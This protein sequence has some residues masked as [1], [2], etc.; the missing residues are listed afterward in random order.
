MTLVRDVIN[1][2]SN[3][4]WLQVSDVVLSKEAV[5][6]MRSISVSR[7]RIEIPWVVD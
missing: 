2:V 4:K 5:A 6:V 1:I 7:L 3:T